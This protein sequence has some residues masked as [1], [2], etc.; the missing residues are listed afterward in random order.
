MLGLCALQL[1]CAGSVDSG[2]AGGD[3]LGTGG[4]IYDVTNT[5]GA[6]GST[7]SESA[8]SSGTK[9]FVIADGARVNVTVAG[10]STPVIWGKLS[11]GDVLGFGYLDKAYRYEHGGTATELLPSGSAGGM[12]TSSMVAPGAEIGLPSLNL[13]GTT[14]PYVLIVRGPEASGAY[15]YI[16]SPCGDAACSN[17]PTDATVRTAVA[18]QPV[19]VGGDYTLEFRPVE[20]NGV[21]KTLFSLRRTT[22]VATSA[23]TSASTSATTAATS[24]VAP[25]APTPPPP[26]PTAPTAPTAPAKAADDGWSMT[27][28]LLLGGAAVGGYVLWMKKC[29]WF[30]IACN[31]A[32][33]NAAGGGPNWGGNDPSLLNGTVGGNTAAFP[34]GYQSATG[35]G[36]YVDAN[37]QVRLRSTHLLGDTWSCY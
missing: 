33:T 6:V 15:G 35:A 12:V 20:L 32:Q 2:A 14:Q 16:L 25:A 17:G 23:S 8:I 29:D 22:A 28:W 19:N 11:T 10:S 13:T 7:A 3:A 18:N 24:S 4:S 37:G 30:D 31:G 9:L 36:C 5:A 27:D 26:P 1:G 21:A 34:Y